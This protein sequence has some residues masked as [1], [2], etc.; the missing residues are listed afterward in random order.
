MKI[1]NIT[2]GELTSEEKTA[3]NVIANITC[4]DL[5]CEFCPL[6]VK[7]SPCLPVIANKL[8]LVKEK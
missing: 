6:N 4:A 7:N 3:I 2:R 5:S 8:K 1:F